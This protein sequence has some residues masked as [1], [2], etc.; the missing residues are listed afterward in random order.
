MILVAGGDSFVYGSELKDGV[1]PIDPT[2][3]APAQQQVS[4]STFTALFAH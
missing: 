3:T 4:Q 2:G 1:T